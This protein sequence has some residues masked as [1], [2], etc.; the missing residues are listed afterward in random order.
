[1]DNEAKALLHKN[2]ILL[3]KNNQLL[4]EA[5]GH[6]NTTIQ[7]MKELITVMRLAFNIMRPT[8]A[9][10]EWLKDAKAEQQKSN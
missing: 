7:T 3:E 6:G 8:K 5:N 4:R 1:M 2:N 10:Q 9:Q